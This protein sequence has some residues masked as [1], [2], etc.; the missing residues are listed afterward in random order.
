MALTQPRRRTANMPTI[1]WIH[2]M[3]HRFRPRFACVALALSL[4]GCTFDLDQAF[5]RPGM[6]ELYSCAQLAAEKTTTINKA[7]E[8]H[9]RKAKAAVGTDGKAIGFLVYEPD[10][11]TT[12]ANLRLIE[13]TAAAK[14]CDQP[15]AGPAQSKH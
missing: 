12:Q 4:V 5:V 13:R 15:N 11:R 2:A 8:L 7:K 10:I 6:Y 14:N 3:A 1:G 9:E